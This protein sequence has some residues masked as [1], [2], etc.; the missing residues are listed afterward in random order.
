[1]LKN[2]SS[3]YYISSLVIDKF[4]KVIQYCAENKFQT[5]FSTTDNFTLQGNID[6]L[7]I[8]EIF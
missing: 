7:D 4:D 6:N 1:M 5:F 8:K 3:N 2:G